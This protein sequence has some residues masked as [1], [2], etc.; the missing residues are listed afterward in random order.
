MDNL[1]EV[2]LPATYARGVPYE[3]FARLRERSPV[4]R[5]PEPAVGPWRAGPGYW[6]VFRHRD[7]RHV[8]RTP[9][10]FSSHTGATQI[11]DPD[12]PGDLAFVQAMMLNTDPPEHSRL[13]RIVSGAFTPRAVRALEETV[14]ARAAGLFRAGRID[15]VTVAA[16]LPVWTLAH[17]MGVPEQDRAL[18]YDWA[19][20]VIGYQDEEYAGT[21]T[22]TGLTEIG[23][24]AARLRPVL[25]PGA[26][27]RSRAALRDMFA[28]AHALAGQV[29]GGEGESVLAAM[30][31]GGLTEAEF[32]NMFFLFA[33]AGNETLGNGIPG[34]L[35][36]L[37]EHP[38]Q[39]ARLRDDPDLLGGAV[40]EM[41]R[42]WP[43]VLH[44]RRTATRDLELGGQRIRAGEK[45]VV[46]H[47]SANRDP[48]V[49]DRPDVFDV[50]R[51]P[52]EH[53]SF[54]DGPHV[55]LG[56]HLARVQMRAVFRELLR[57]RVELDG[58]PVRL[59]SN[60]Q[61]GLKHLPVR[62]TPRR[63][64]RSVATGAPGPG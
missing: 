44:F 2:F 4:C 15:F 18:L 59:T 38:G 33:V 11:R 6:A 55:C 9:A 20:R 17:V 22:A 26:N 35:L 27:P 41:L 58:P 54:G 32:E 23:R 30:L 49:F 29:R 14:A 40:E 60:F 8:L 53:L 36:T 12:T 13:R 16:D 31:R 3:L 28:Y 50:G 10:D 57:W 7:V 5:V 51:A 52:N 39:F 63:V 34:G 43:P 48:A 46:Y 47:A 42:Y 61:N 24:Q 56:A 21:A 1:A 45:V 62:L 19:S 25:E 37:L 64:R